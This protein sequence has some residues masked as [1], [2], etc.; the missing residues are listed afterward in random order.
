MKASISLICGVLLTVFFSCFVGGCSSTS[1]AQSQGSCC[2][3]WTTFRARGYESATAYR[4]GELPEYRL[5]IALG[6]LSDNGRNE[7]LRGFRTA[8]FDADDGPRGQEYSEILKQSLE[9]GHYEEA[10]VQG[11]KYVSGETTDARVQELI[12]GSVGLTRGSGLGWKAGYIT[13]FSREMAR[14]RSGVEENFYRQAETKYN[15]LR[16]PLGV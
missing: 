2:G 10:V 16:S 15:A 13:G 7:F 5:V 11:K 1:G 4:A 6:S 12:G 9:G 8:Y 14:Q 3:L